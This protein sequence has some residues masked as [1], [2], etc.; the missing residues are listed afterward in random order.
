LLIDPY[1][2]AERSRCDRLKSELSIE[3]GGV[4][5]CHET[6]VGLRRG[7]RFDVLHQHRHDHLPKALPLM[8]RIDGDIHDVEE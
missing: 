3:A 1:C 4:P 7:G 5:V 2:H 8:V 6:D